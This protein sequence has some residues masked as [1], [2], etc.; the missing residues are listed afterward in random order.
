MGSDMVWPKRGRKSEANRHH[1]EY[2]GRI[3][4]TAEQI[5]RAGL[6]DGPILDVGGAPGHNL[7]QKWGLPNVT[8]LDVDPKADLVASADDIPLDTG[9]FPTVTCI[10][11][12]EHIPRTRR[13]DVVREMVRVADRLVVIVAPVDS[14]ENN[15]AERL[16]LEYNDNHRLREHQ[17]EGL[18]DFGPIESVLDDLA[19]RGRVMGW[20]RAELD[21]LLTWVMLMTRGRADESAV[22]QQAYFL[23][24]GFFPRRIGLSVRVAPPA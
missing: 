11:T 13:L 15:R 21:H 22:Y 24:N 5:K 1:W 7:L 4:W 6:S 10:D 2:F 12:L 16:V 17:A 9:A 19:G 23:E 3:N 20:D 14:P 8:T 18:V